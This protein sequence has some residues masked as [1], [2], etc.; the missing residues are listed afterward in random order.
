MISLRG[1]GC[2]S[3]RGIAAY[4]CWYSLREFIIRSRSSR[5]VVGRHRRILPCAVRHGPFVDRVIGIVML[6]GMSRRTRHDYASP[7]TGGGRPSARRR[8]G[9]GP[10]AA[11]ARMMTTFADLRHPADPLALAPAPTAAATRRWRCGRPHA[12]QL[13]TL[14]IPR[15]LRLP[16]SY[17]R[18]ISAASPSV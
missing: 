3:W 8:S 12:L 16:R 2:C 1:Q 4:V 17:D 10:A 6:V 9:S 5:P 11:S 13:L 14:F 7:S 15:G 18:R